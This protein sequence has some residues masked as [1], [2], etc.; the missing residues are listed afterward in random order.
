[1]GSFSINIEYDYDFSWDPERT[2]H[3]INFHFYGYDTW[4]FDCKKVAWYNIPGH[5]HNLFE[6][7]IPEMIAGDGTPF[8]ITYDFY[9]EIICKDTCLIF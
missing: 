7:I 4:E 2:A 6:E 9:W 1:M 5:F 8:D 3:Y